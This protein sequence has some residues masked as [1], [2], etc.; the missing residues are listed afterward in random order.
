LNGENN[1]FLLENPNIQYTENEIINLKRYFSR[2]DHFDRIF[3]KLC[4]YQRKSII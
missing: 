1:L 3:D 2:S 4:S